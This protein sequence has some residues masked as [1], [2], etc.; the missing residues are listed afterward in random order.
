ME[1]DYTCLNRNFL[2]SLKKNGHQGHDYDYKV[3]L[4]NVVMKSRQVSVW[5]H[6]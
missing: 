5:S 2:V 6:V 1:C 4:L 3:S